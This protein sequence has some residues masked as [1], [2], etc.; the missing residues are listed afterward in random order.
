MSGTKSV[1]GIN[2]PVSNRDC[3]QEIRKVDVVE[4]E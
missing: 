4:K 2:L 1:S 3:G